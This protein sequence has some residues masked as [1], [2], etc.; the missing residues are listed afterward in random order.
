[1]KNAPITDRI[2]AMLGQPVTA[3]TIHARFPDGLVTLATV[4]RLLDELVTQ[5]VAHSRIRG[6]LRFYAA[7]PR[8][9]GSE[10]R[11]RM[12]DEPA[13][14]PKAPEYVPLK[15]RPNQLREEVLLLV[16]AHPFKTMGELAEVF[17]P[18]RDREVA[19]DQVQTTLTRLYQKGALVRFGQCG[20]YRYAVRGQRIEC[21][22]NAA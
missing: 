20:Q 16:A 8:A 11:I 4:C 6:R 3:R 12:K 13:P 15:R 10:P 21:G 9:F 22:R 5:G 18:D 2:L 1:M 19:R 14:K 7:D 17:A